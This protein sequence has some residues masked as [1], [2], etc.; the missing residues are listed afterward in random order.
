MMHGQMYRP[1]AFAVDDLTTL[2]RV[3]RERVFATFAASHDGILRFAYAP[4]VVDAEDGPLGGVGFHLARNNPLADM[5]DGAR[6]SLSAIA[7]DAYVSPDWYRTLVTVPTWN[8]VAVEGEGVVRRLSKDALRHLLEA[9]AADEERKLAPKPPWTTD[10]VPEPRV[11]AMLNA[12][13]GFALSF[14]RLQG[15]FKLSQDKTP[16]DRAGVIG[17]LD[18]RGD[19]GSAAVMRAMKAVPPNVTPAT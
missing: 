9:L 12:I 1:S 11:E 18:A 15:K 10:K 4:V 19:P 7:C 13:A 3:L 5:P 14:E 2:H 6:L 8:Y 17:G 16:E